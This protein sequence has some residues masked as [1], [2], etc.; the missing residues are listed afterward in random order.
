MGNLPSQNDV[1]EI[2]GKIMVN[3]FNID[4]LN[5]LQVILLCFATW[6]R[7][8]VKLLFEFQ[9]YVFNNNLTNLDKSRPFWTDFDQFELF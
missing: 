8:N 5:I 6:K 4:D 7:M 3:A 9:M 1:L 2:Y